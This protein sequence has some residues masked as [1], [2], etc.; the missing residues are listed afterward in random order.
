MLL[1]HNLTG[2]RLEFLA[3]LATPAAAFE[4]LRDQ[5]A[6]WMGAIYFQVS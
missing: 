6:F 1:R 3:D 2:S 5:A 4:C